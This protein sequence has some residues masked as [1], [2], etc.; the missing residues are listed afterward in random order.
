M[1]INLIK[2]YIPLLLAAIL[3]VVG[4]VV[5]SGIGRQQLV[6]IDKQTR[7][8]AMLEDQVA[9]LK[10][11]ESA[12]VA[13]IERETTGL[14]DIRHVDDDVVADKFFSHIFSWSSLAEYNAIRDELMADQTMTEDS[15]FMK[16]VMPQ[17]EEL[18]TDG[19]P[20]NVIDTGILNL[21]YVDMTSYVIGITTKAYQYFTEVKVRSKDAGG[22]TSIGT[23]A[24]TYAVDVDGRI[25]GLDAYT[26]MP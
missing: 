19:E 6:A 15:R 17:V 25:G 23:I 4:L 9:V 12:E 26:V 5:G 18:P 7:E 14:D 13:N 11:A 16:V 3:L 10:A 1:V 22:N 21:S 24:V 2:R 20:I 8:I